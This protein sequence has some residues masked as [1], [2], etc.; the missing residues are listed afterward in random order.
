MSLRLKIYTFPS[1]TKKL[2]KHVILSFT[3]ITLIIH[4]EYV[5]SIKLRWY[6]TK[7]YILLSV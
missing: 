2:Y 6:T 1:V 5:R 7:E 3:R 4:V